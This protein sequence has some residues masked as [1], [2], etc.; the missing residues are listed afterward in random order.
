M[1]KVTYLLWEKIR[2]L[3]WEKV[4]WH[5]KKLLDVEKYYL[6]WEKRDYVKEKLYSWEKYHS[7]GKIDLARGKL[8]WHGKIDLAWEKGG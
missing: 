5:G 3:M 8:T 4:T 1:E 6:V 2:Y 7:G